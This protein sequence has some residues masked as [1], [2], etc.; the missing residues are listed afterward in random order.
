MAA[1]IAATSQADVSTQ[2]VEGLT[3]F[4]VGLTLFVMT[5][6]LNA[7]SIRFV[8]RYRQVYE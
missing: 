3:L 4:A 8:R 5:L 1:F 7:I 6:L 2:G